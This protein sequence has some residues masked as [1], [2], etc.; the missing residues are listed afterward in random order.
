LVDEAVL[1]EALE[2]G[3]ILSAGL[4]VYAQ[5]HHVPQRLI[6]LPQVVLLPHVGS[7]SVLTRKAISQLVIDNLDALAQGKKPLTPVPETPVG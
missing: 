3:K 2:T 6:D 5:E 7:S 4:D 1:I